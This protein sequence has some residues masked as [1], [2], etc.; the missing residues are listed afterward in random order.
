MRW[1]ED[2]RSP[3]PGPVS[4]ELARHVAAKVYGDPDVFNSDLTYEKPEAKAL[5]ALWHSHRG[6]LVGSLVLCDREHSRV[7]SAES[8]D[9]VADTALMSKLFSACTGYEVSESELDRAGERIWNQLRAIDIRNYNRDR[10]VDEST[11]DGFMYPGKDDG[12]MLD[13]EAFQP[14]LD[15]YYELSG[16]NPAS[17]WPT[18]SKLEELG[19]GDVAD[20]LQAINKLG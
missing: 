19:L 9:G 12:V 10:V 17:G 3:N 5:P 7:F 20:E 2:N 6:M 8:E 14:L 4:P 1:L 18:R 11:L 15:S 16:W 13:R